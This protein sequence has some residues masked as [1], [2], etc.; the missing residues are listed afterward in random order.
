VVVVQHTTHIV[1]SN[2]SRSIH[3]KHLNHK[4]NIFLINMCV[5]MAVYIEPMDIEWVR[6]LD[7]YFMG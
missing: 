1:I 3:D 4:K 6:F 2:N 5:G 7:S